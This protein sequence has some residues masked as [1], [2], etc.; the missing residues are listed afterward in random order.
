MLPDAKAEPGSVT[1]ARSAP[2]GRPA[3][4]GRTESVRFGG[5][6]PQ[7][8]QKSWTSVLTSCPVMPAMKVWP[9]QAGG[10][11]PAPVVVP[12]VFCWSSSGAFASMTPPGLVV[13]SS[14]ADGTPPARK[15]VCVVSV[16]Q[17]L[18]G[19]A[20]EDEVWAVV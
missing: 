13:R 2:V 6:A 9:V 18:V 20:G 5:V 15:S 3:L 17:A 4:V 12:A 7:P 14:A 16:R 11:K 10:P 19:A 8:L 1:E